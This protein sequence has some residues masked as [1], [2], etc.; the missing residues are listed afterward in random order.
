MTGEDTAKKLERLYESH[1]YWSLKPKY[2]QAEHRDEVV[3]T[4]MRRAC[5]EEILEIEGAR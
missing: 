4:K 5:L 1:G 2:R 3:A